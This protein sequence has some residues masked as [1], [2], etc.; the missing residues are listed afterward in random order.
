MEL[1]YKL[2]KLIETVTGKRC[3]NCKYC[4]GL[5]CTSDNQEKCVNSLFPVGYERRS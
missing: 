3:E 4:N 2:Q 5:T 1:K